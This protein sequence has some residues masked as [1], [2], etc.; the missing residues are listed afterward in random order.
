MR[1]RHFFFLDILILLIAPFLSLVLRLETFYPNKSFLLPLYTY[2]ACSLI[3]HFSGFYISGIYHR[4]WQEASVHELLSSCFTILL[5]NII[6]III[7]LISH[8]YF[9]NSELFP[10]THLKKFPRSVPFIH[11]ILFLLLF[12][13]IRFSLRSWQHI[14]IYNSSNFSGTP[15]L[16][17][18]SGDIARIII[19][20]TI[21]TNFICGFLDDNTHKAKMRI[22]G[23]PV[24]GKIS[25]IN[26]IISKYNIKEVIICIPNATGILIQNIIR[27]SKNSGAKVKIAVDTYK[28][29]DSNKTPTYE[30]RKINVE[31]LLRR[32]SIEFDMTDVK[33]AVYNKVI[34]VT[35]AGGSIGSELCQQ[36][37]ALHPQRIILL[38][39][40]ENSIFKIHKKLKEQTS[41][42][43]DSVIADIRFKKRMECILQK[44]TPDIVFHAAAHKHVPLMEDNPGEAIGNN[45]LGSYNLLQACIKNKVS[46]FILI[47]TDKAVNPSSI[48]GATK[49][50]TEFLVNNIAKKH[51]VPYV[52]VRFGNILNSRGSVV[53]TFEQQIV[54]GGPITITHP[55]MERFFMTIPEAVQ[56][57]LQAFSLG[58]AGDIFILDMGKPIKIVD[59]AT[60]LITLYG[61][62]T[63]HIKIEFIGMRKGEKL[64]ESLS[65]DKETCDRTTYEKI[66]H[67]TNTELPFSNISKT[68]EKFTQLRDNNDKKE[69]ISFFKELISEFEIE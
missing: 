32:K 15:T 47:S 23:K 62:S 67:V 31:D 56:L 27:L 7:C 55:D 10:F 1:N 5:C 26:N 41:I 49:R 59:L 68:I 60:D 13:I 19:K 44:Y 3:I 65:Y 12:M 37:L 48:M 33:Q 20:K 64:Q 30:I 18:G 29:I 34:L 42:I 22:S 66:L 45:I 63:D 36:L 9:V 43:I 2:I 6:L 61:L 54:S 38:G 52:C 28:I 53:Q 40:G 14:S 4:Y 58:K 21:H 57:V 50:I 24:L 11:G 39:H 17:V 46:K 35:G 69:I 16:L 8:T 25:E 51:N